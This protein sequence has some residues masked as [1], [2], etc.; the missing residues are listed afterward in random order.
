MSFLYQQDLYEVIV[1]V[2]ADFPIMQSTAF[3]NRFDMRE[4]AGSRNNPFAVKRIGG[5]RGEHVPKVPDVCPVAA[6]RFCASSVN[7][8]P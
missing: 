3:S 7:F 4:T 8:S 5:D 1:T 6:F 2:H